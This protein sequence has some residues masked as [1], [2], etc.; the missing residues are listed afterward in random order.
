MS[1]DVVWNGV[2]DGHDSD[3]LNE[4]IRVPEKF[5]PQRGR[6]DHSAF[7]RIVEALR[8][9]QAPLRIVDL[10]SQ[11]RVN[12]ATVHSALYLLRQANRL[13][14]RCSEDRRTRYGQPQREY[15]LLDES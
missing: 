6:S 14:C 4:A 15:W 9:A 8:V 3:L 10:E 7:G 5:H 13:G 11:T 1:Y 2:N 12:K